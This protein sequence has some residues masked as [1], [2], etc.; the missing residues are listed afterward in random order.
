MPKLIIADTS[1]LI[2]LQKI[3]RLHLLKDIFE[4]IIITKE[5][6]YEYRE[7]LPI[8]IITK[9][10]KD[11]LSKHILEIDLDKGEASAIA[12]G[13]ENKDVLI[14]IDE[15]K[16]RK[17]ATDLGLKIMGT[18]GVIINAKERGILKSV[19][20]ELE[21]LIEVDFRMSKNLIENIKKNYK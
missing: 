20:E 7:E 18:L 19:I 12:L 13:L 16:G 4:E 2:V 10:V 8:W 6:A 21:K 5:I 1:C 15:R 17:K 11:K 9:K 14:L 3:N